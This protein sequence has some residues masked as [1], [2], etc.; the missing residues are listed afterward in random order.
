MRDF[1]NPD[2]TQMMLLPPCIEDWLPE[3]HLARFIAEVIQ[4]LDL[5]TIEDQYESC[6]KPAYS[7]KL[8]TGLLFYGYATGVFSSRKIEQATHDSIAFRYLSGDTHPDHDT[9]AEFRKRFLT[10]LKDLFFQILVLA[11]E[12]NFVKLG[13]VSIDGTKIKANAS[14]HRAMSWKK[15]NEIE[16]QLKKEVNHLLN[17]AEKTDKKEKNLSGFD[18]PAE[19]AI[20]QKRLAKI[21]EAKAAILD[22]AKEQ[23]EEKSK[24][25]LESKQR[26]DE[27]R[28]AGKPPRGRP[29]VPPTGLPDDKDQYNFTDNESRIMKSKGTFEQA[30]NAQA[31]V[32]TESMLI[33]ANDCSNRENDKNELLPVLGKI[34]KKLGKPK[35]VLADSGYYNQKALVKCRKKGIDPYVAVG[36]DSHNRTL[37]DRLS[38]PKRIK[39]TGTFKEIMASKLRTPHG[40]KIY[41]VRKTTSEPVFGIIKSA[42]RFFRFS[43]RGEENAAGEWSLVCSAFNI[44]RLFNLQYGI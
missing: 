25:Y 44:K 6:G 12:L 34:D 31:A 42:M 4:S 30:Y 39:R 40:Q 23:I 2:R 15:A 13:I 26:N 11:K 19:I 38:A 1:I 17:K 33:V 16:A 22:R 14:K 20:R 41:S 28:K 36:R 29:P 27:Q 32:D 7:P 18:I 3:K 10:E 37:A 5:S 43:L 21:A 24:A 9:I 8:L 35:K